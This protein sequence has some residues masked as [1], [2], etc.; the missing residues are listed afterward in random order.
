MTDRCETRPPAFGAVVKDVERNKFGEFRA[1]ECGRFYL[2]PVGGGR[3]WD[4][5]A[6]DVRQATYAETKRVC[7]ASSERGRT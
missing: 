2:R 3:E 6:S 5:P 1:V 7:A 4:A